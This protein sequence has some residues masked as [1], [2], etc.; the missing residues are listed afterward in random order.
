MEVEEQRGR[1]SRIPEDGYRKEINPGG[2]ETEV[3]EDSLIKNNNIRK[4]IKKVYKV[5]YRLS[6]DGV[7]HEEYKKP[8]EAEEDIKEY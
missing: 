7:E 5:I 4:D 6:D 8:F 1:S 2:W 3:E